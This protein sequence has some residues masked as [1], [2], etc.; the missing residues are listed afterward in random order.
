[1]GDSFFTLSARFRRGTS[2]VSTAVYKVC[3]AIWNIMSPVYMKP[4]T[5]DDWRQ[6][7]HRFSTRWN[8]NNCVGALDGKHVM[9]RSP[10]NSQSLFYNCKGFFSIN[11]MAL[12]D[13]DY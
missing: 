2:T 10:P 6:I 7:E 9:I 13:A 1:M 4:T 8:F 12:V 5:E 3:D 11:L